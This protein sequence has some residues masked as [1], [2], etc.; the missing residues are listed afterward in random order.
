M[1]SNAGKKFLTF[2]KRQWRRYKVF[3]E[4]GIMTSPLEQ[5]QTECRYC[6]HVFRGNYCPRC[7]QNRNI[8][9]EQPSVLGT[10]RDA[11]PQ[12]S[13]NYIRT[14]L[15]L[16]F[17]PGYMLR[18]YFRGHRVIYNPPLNVLVITLS[19]IALGTG[20][21]QKISGQDVGNENVVS[22]FFDA[23]HDKTDKNK[24]T[25]YQTLINKMGWIEPGKD[26]KELSRRELILSMIQEKV[27]DYDFVAIFVMFPVMGFSSYLAFRKK[28]VGD[29]KLSMM[30]HYIVMVYLY[31]PLF[32][33]V[34]SFPVRVFYFLWTYHGL[35]SLPWRKAAVHTMV[36]LAWTTLFA[37]LLIILV[38]ALFIFVVYV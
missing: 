34:P 26:K 24:S 36:M 15:Q 22:A 28:R 5:T 14:M 1:E 4:R 6:G 27:F 18:D 38:S 37:I 3:L 10:F 11:Y 8:C 20:I 32:L 7:G 17:R 2:L 25:F 33:L 30:E 13:N 16:I 31:A 19:V 35:Y 29:R 9:S 12:L 21:Y 23:A